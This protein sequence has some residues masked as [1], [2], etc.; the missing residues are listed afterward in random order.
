MRPCASRWPS[1]SS[2]RPATSIRTSSA[3]RRSRRRPPAAEHASS[4]CPSTSNS[5]GVMT[6]SGRRRDRCRSLHGRLRRRRAEARRWIL[7]G[8][9]AETSDDPTRPYNTSTLIAPDGSIAARYRKVH[10]FDVAVDEGP[11]D[12]ESARVS[13]GDEPVVADVDGIRLGLSVCYDLRFPELYRT[14]ALAGAEVLA[15]PSNF[16]ERTGRDHWEVLLR[17]RAIENGAWVRA[18]SVGRT[19]RPARVRSLDDHRPVGNRCRAGV[20]RRRDRPG[21]R[22]DGPRRRGPSSDPVPG[23]QAAERL[24]DGLGDPPRGGLPERHFTS[25]T[26]MAPAPWTGPPVTGP[27]VM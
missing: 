3:P 7:A 17:A 25:W 23:Q 13:P 1:S 5:A 12:T 2:T 27:E 11:V 16:T 22:G 14:L 19:A 9:I 24:P 21:G 8:S 26:P 20:G 10:L 18:R 6:V 4:F 15:V